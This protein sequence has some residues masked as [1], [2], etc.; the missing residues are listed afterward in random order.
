MFFSKYKVNVS[1]INYGGHMGNERALILFQQCRID[2]FHF[3]GLSEIN[4]GDNIGTIQKDAHVNYHKE[5]FLGTLLTIRI[6]NIEL[7]RTSFNVFY[8]ILN[9]DY[10]TLIDGST[11][12]VAYDYEKKKISKLPNI[13]KDSLNEYLKNIK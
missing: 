3:L 10:E 5:I 9:Q 2:F 12:I 11:L 6:K 13:F 7:S 1:D 8:E 4:I